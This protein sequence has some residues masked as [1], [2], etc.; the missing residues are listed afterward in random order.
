M[1]RTSQNFADKRARYSAGHAALILTLDKAWLLR[2]VDRQ[3]GGTRPRWVLTSRFD[4]APTRDFKLPVRSVRVLFAMPNDAAADFKRLRGA[5]ALE[6]H[7]YLVPHSALSHTNPRLR[8]LVRGMLAS[9][10]L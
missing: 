3:N 8:E 1:S 4:A 7:E 10:A 6:A 9:H 2:E 5:V